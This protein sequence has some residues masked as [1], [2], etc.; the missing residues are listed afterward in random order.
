MN[1][2]SSASED[3]PESEELGVQ[4]EALGLLAKL[5]SDDGQLAFEDNSLRPERNHDVDFERL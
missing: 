1:D 5:S 3:E 4:L 2:W